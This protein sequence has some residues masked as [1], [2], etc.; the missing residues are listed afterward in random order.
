VDSLG[1]QA[2]VVSRCDFQAFSRTDFLVD[3]PFRSTMATI[4]SAS[5]P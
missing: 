2:I 3:R 5:V 4:L 1:G